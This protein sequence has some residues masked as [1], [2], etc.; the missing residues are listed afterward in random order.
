MSVIAEFTIDEEEFALGSILADVPDVS[1]ELDQIT[2]RGSRGVPY[3]WVTG[4]D[5]DTFERMT[6]SCIEFR[7]KLIRRVCCS[8]SGKQTPPSSK[9]IVRIG[10]GFSNPIRRTRR[11]F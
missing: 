11:S 2:S 10:T 5:H 9:R 8:K 6:V 1:V 7:G 3:L 4:D